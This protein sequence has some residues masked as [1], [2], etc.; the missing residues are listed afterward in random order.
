MKIIG[1]RGAAGIATENTVN[2]I[3]AGVTAGADAVEF[4][5]RLSKDDLFILNH[6][7]SLERMTGSQER[8]RNLTMNELKKIRTL[9]GEPL[10][11]LEEALV[12]RA[13]ATAVIEPKGTK[14]AKPLADYLANNAVTNFCLISFNHTELSVFHNL[15]PE[16]NCYALER[17]NAFKAIATARRHGLYGVDLNFWILNPFTYWFA[18]FNRMDILIYTVDRPG[19]M[20]WFAWMYPR[21]GITTNYPNILSRIK[22]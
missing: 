18:K 20:R 13:A 4:D 15:M 19:Y 14:W 8:V 11:T 3:K 21:V 9:S 7:S 17:Q 1:H 5:V 6:D 12:A 22:K 2:A 16:V 10:A